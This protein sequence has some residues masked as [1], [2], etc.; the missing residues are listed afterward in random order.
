MC[1]DEAA[2]RRLHLEMNGF[3]RRRRGASEG[4][5]DPFQLAP[6]SAGLR[7]PSPAADVQMSEA[8]DEREGT[9]LTS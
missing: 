9:P 5:F 3:A 2:A 1:T 6:V 8:G 7:V 4:A